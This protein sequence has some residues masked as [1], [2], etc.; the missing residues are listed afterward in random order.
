MFSSMCPNVAGDRSVL[1]RYVERVEPGEGGRPKYRCTICGKMNGQK[2]HTEN[3]VESIHFPGA[4]QYTC[5]YCADT[6]TGRN[7]LYLHVNQFHKKM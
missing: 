7:K 5:R 3:H 1:C 4:F 6:F 2:A